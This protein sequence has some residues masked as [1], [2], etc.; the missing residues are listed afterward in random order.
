MNRYTLSIFKNPE[1][2][3]TGLWCRYYDAKLYIDNYANKLANLDNKNIELKKL[4]ESLKLMC[5]AEQGH[6]AELGRK[7]K[8]LLVLLVISLSLN[9]FRII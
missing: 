3:K 5:A 2:C 9:I 1:M 7:I 6:T 8:F 4:N